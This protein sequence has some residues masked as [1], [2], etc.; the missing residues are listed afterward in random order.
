VN[1]EFNDKELESLVNYV[2]GIKPKQ[3]TFAFSYPLIISLICVCFP[4][5]WIYFEFGNLFENPTQAYIYIAMLTFPASIISISIYLL[6]TKS[7]K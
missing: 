2:K 5:F 3:T 6:K 4:I 7:V 1:S